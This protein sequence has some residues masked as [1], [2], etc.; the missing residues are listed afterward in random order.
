MKQSNGFYEGTYAKYILPGVLL[1]SV[2]IGS[3]YATGREIFSYGA[4]F[5]AMGWISGLTIGIGFALFAF[6]TFEICRIYKVYDYK[7]YIKQVIGPLWPVMDILTVLIAVMLIAVM[8][9]ATGSIF[10]QVH[11]PNILGSVVIVLLC[12]LLNF[13]GAK[14]IEKFESIGTILLYA[15]YILFTIVVLVKRGSH[16]PEVFATMDTSAFEGKTT[17]ML[18]VWTGI[19][20]VAYNINSIPMGMFSLTRQTKRKETL[21]SGI[22][23]GLLMVIPWFLSYFAMLCFYGDTSIVGADVATPWTQMIVASD[24]GAALLV[25]FSIVMGWTLVET[26]TG[27]IH[28]IIDR[29]DVALVEKGHAR[30]SDH[31]RGII[32]VITLVLALVLSRIGVVTLIEQGYTLLSYGFILFYLLPTLII[33]GYKIIKHKD[34]QSQ[35]NK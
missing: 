33:G 9:A 7:N 18:C 5:G 15:G 12:G 28:M 6:L 29:F 26:A 14:V 32:T 30:M 17:V 24:G 20:Y 3:G 10:E 23:A 13:K 35:H 21:I 2:L 4:K 25:L 22:I 19:L 16:I 31:R 34:A 8:A 27:C 1:Q 11:L